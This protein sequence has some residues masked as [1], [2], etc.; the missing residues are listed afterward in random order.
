MK[1]AIWP[2]PSTRSSRPTPTRRK[3][4]TLPKYVVTN[5]LTEGT[6][7]PTVVLKGDPVH[8]VTELRRASENVIHA[9]S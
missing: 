3:C 4:F 2:G 5:T 7:N 8:A 1:A 6:W 9:A